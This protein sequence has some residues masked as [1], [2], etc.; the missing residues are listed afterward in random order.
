MSLLKRSGL[1][2]A[3]ALGLFSCQPKP[4]QI[5]EAIKQDPEGFFK[6]VQ[7]AEGKYREVAMKKQQ[8]EMMQQM[9]KDFE[10]PLKP[11]LDPKRAYLGPESAPV[12][13]VEYSDFECPACAGGFQTI[14]AVKAKYGDQVRFLYKHMPLER[15]HPGARRAAQYFEAVAMQS[16]ELAYQFHDKL[17]ENQRRLVS[18]GEKF[19]D[20][21]AKSLK[22]DMKRL[23]ADL[24][25]SQVAQNISK[26]MAEFENFGFQ[27]TPG[28]LVNGVSIRGA[29]RPD[30]FH[31]IIDRQLN[32]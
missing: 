8:E 28:F 7:E 27:G 31:Q 3:T 4:E 2:V 11:E 15:I 13:I 23:K 9:E 30:V 22:V 21:T 25:S 14:K 26:D 16:P 19:L 20:E 32:K 1:I 29:A 6:A 12:T 18:E 24:K 5:F 17:F 10:N